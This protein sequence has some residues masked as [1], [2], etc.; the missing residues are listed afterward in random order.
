M[1]SAVV[2]D[3]ELR[4][5]VADDGI[6]MDAETRDRIFEPFFSARPD[7]SGTGLGMS[8]VRNAVT[9]L[10]GECTVEANPGE[11]ARVRVRLGRDGAAAGTRAT[12]TGLSP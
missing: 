9:S 11:G 1:V 10:G 3:D 6:G 12:G 4:L 8:I 5:E 2:E 7:G